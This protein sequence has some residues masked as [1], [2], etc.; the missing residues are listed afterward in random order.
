MAEDIENL[1]PNQIPHKTVTFSEKKPEVKEEDEFDGCIFHPRKD[2]RQTE[3]ACKCSVKRAKFQT[4][5]PCWQKTT[6]KLDE[7]WALSEQERLK[8][9]SRAYYQPPS[10]AKKNDSVIA[11]KKMVRDKA[12]KLI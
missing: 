9:T 2:S 7:K 5:D 8:S 4:S 10:S 12:F 6:Y 11:G 3:S 1:Q